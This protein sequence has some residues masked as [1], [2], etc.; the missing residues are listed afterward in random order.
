MIFTNKA[1]VSYKQFSQTWGNIP[2]NSPYETGKTISIDGSGPTCAAMLISTITGE[3]YTPVDACEWSLAHGWKITDNGTSY[4]YFTNQFNAFGIDCFRLNLTSIGHKP[5]HKIHDEALDYLNRGYYLICLLDISHQL[6][7]GTSLNCDRYIIIY[8]FDDK[9]A[10]VSDPNSFSMNKIPIEFM[11][12]E[13]K[14]YWVIDGRK[15]NRP[16]L[17]KEESSELT[18]EKFMEMFNEAMRSYLTEHRD[19]NFDHNGISKK[20]RDFC[21]ANKIFQ[22]DCEEDPDFMWDD[23]LTKEQAAIIIYNTA[24]RFGLID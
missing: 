9:Y 14:Y 19:I 3:H 15:I 12:N 20:A 18:K 5:D 7:N 2:Y 21:V 10:Y 1:P 4:H 24:V 22:C 6:L 13:V 16:E 23:F 17:I 11:R 8:D